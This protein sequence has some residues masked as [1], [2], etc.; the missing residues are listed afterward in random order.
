MMSLFIYLDLIWGHIRGQAPIANIYPN[1]SAL[2]KTCQDCSIAIKMSTI[3]ANY[4]KLAHEIS[5]LDRLG[6]NQNLITM[7]GYFCKS[8]TFGIVFELL[9][10]SFNDRIVSCTGKH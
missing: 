4:D 1:V 7:L 9:E 5:I 2:K 3:E 10:K 8:K 6:Y